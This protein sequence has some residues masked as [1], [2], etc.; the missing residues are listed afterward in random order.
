MLNSTAPTVA[1]ALDVIRKRLA[2]GTPGPLTEDNAALIA[3][4]VNLL[5]ALADAVEAAYATRDCDMDRFSC[6]DCHPAL[7]AALAR[8]AA[9]VAGEDEA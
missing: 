5:P 9:A 8:V 6:E 7:M 4:A 3:L 1:D 2:A